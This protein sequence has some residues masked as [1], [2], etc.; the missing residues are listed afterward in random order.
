MISIRLPKF[1]RVGLVRLASVRRGTRRELRRETPTGCRL[2]QLAIIGCIVLADRLVMLPF[3]PLKVAVKK[4]QDLK[5]IKTAT[6]VTGNLLGVIFVLFVSLTV[7]SLLF[8][9]VILWIGEH[10]FKDAL[11]GTMAM[12]LTLGL[13]VAGS[14]ILIF[15]L[16]FTAQG[17]ARLSKHC[18]I[19]IRGIEETIQTQLAPTLRENG[20][21]LAEYALILALIAS[22][23]MLALAIMN[24]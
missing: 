5:P 20:Q 10:S 7:I 23:C 21:G 8:M 16:R 1:V 2:M 24:I 9:P 19:R 14:T 15:T 18:P 6:M 11:V 3:W 17:L 22:V 13:I 12:W 4:S